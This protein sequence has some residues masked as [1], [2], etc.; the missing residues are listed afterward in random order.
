M[1]LDNF[2]IL[3]RKKYEK[4]MKETGKD[5][6]QRRE[7][8]DIHAGVNEGKILELSVEYFVSSGG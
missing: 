8:P 7:G 1:G 6:I 4:G 3:I 2:R 5:N